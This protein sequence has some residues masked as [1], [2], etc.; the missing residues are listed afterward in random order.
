MMLV[1]AVVVMILLL[2]PIVNYLDSEIFN[3]KFSLL[4]LIL[5]PQGSR[6]CLSSPL[7]GVNVLTILLSGTDLNFNFY[8]I[9][10]R[11]LLPI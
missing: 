6:T 1:V 2:L 10:Y 11:I 8:L 5:G 3:C 9:F 4:L 7:Q